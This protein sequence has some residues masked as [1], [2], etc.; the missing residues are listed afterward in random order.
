MMVHSQL[1]GYEG[2]C[3]ILAIVDAQGVCLATVGPTLGA[4]FCHGFSSPFHK[5]I[6]STGPTGLKTLT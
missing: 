2:G 1:L 4:K 3:W 6:S 5:E